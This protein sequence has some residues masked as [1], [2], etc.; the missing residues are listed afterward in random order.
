MNGRVDLPL[1]AAKMKMYGNAAGADG[2]RRI[3]GINP[4]E[5]TVAK[6]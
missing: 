2:K 3:Q 5:K 4:V 1:L 6:L